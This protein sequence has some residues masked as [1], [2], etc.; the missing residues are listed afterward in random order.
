MLKNFNFLT[1]IMEKWKG[2]FSNENV[3]KYFFSVYFE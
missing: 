3:T 2:L 1:K